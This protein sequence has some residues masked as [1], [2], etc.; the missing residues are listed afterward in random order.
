MAVSEALAPPDIDPDTLPSAAIEAERTSDAR[1]AARAGSPSLGETVVAA[2]RADCENEKAPE[3][4]TLKLRL[5]T[6]AP[7]PGR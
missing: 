2:A 4:L 3:S 1:A 7:A 6:G 5:I